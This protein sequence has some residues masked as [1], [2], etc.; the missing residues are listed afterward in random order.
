M[1]L[2][3]KVQLIREKIVKAQDHYNK[4]Y[5]RSIDLQQVKSG[6]MMEYNILHEKNRM[7][8]T[9]ETVSQLHSREVNRLR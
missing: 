4:S 7:E 9:G 5:K 1:I 2:H 3:Y 6:A 8:V